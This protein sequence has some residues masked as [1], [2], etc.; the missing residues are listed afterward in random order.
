MFRLKIP[1]PPHLRGQFKRRNGQKGKLGKPGPESAYLRVCLF[2]TLHHQA[3]G[4][5]PRSRRRRRRRSARSPG[6]PPAPRPVLHMIAVA[7]AVQ[8]RQR[9]TS[10]SRPGHDGAHPDCEVS[11]TCRW[12]P[13]AYTGVSPGP[14]RRHRD[15]LGARLTVPATVRRHWHR[16]GL[17]PVVI[18]SQVQ[19]LESH[20][21]G[22]A[23]PT[24]MPLAVTLAAADS[25]WQ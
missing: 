23:R 2:C 25:D 8:G 18:S 6:G 5:A 20:R 24:R 14:G 10:D 19:V 21:D 7:D 15:R 16:G 9:I 22:H 4:P 1:G 12:L 11:E 17:G 3:I 13:L